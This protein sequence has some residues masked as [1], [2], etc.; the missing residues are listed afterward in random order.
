MENKENN[1]QQFTIKNW[2][3]DYWLIAL[4]IF[5]LIVSIAI[6]V[7]VVYSYMLY[8][9][10]VFPNSTDRADWGAT[11]DFLGGILNPTFAFL[12]LFMLLAT[13]YQTQKDLTLTRK[14]LADQVSTQKQQRFENTFFSLLDQHNKFADAVKNTKYKIPWSEMNSSIS[15]KKDMPEKVRTKFR[16]DVDNNHIEIKTYCTFLYQILK[17]I[18]EQHEDG[19]KGQVSERMKFY[20]NLIRASIDLNLGEIILVN[21]IC[22]SGDDPWGY[23]KFR[24][25]IECFSFLEHVK[26]DFYEHDIFIAYEEYDKK[27]LD[28]FQIDPYNLHR[29]S[30]EHHKKLKK[31]SFQEWESSIKNRL[32][33]YNEIVRD[34]RKDKYYCDMAYGENPSDRHFYNRLKWQIS[35]LPSYML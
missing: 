20:S 16:E 24:D 7:F 30:E 25:L 15:D 9:S 33:F 12:A 29:Y 10:T 2:L 27:L 8:Q 3:K 11:G 34:N 22:T 14:E 31:E 26:I 18:Y 19:R 1:P 13:L 4:M 23:R 28:E 6:M 17:F 35:K 5:L 32:H 21:S